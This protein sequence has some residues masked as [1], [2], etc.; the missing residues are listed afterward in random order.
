MRI[1]TMLDYGGGWRGSV[2]RV[3]EL[4]RA[5]L[6]HVCVAEAWGFDSPSLLVVPHPTG[7]GTAA[8]LIA[9]VKELAA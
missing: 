7:G 4:G 9:Y 1:A 6:D 3:R 5:G 2:E 8:D